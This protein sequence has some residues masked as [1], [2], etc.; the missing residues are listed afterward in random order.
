MA[1]KNKTELKAESS[2]TFPTNGVRQI[3]A[4]NHRAFN[5]DL[6]DSLDTVVYNG[7]I[8]QIK[9]VYVNRQLLVYGSWGLPNSAGLG[10]MDLIPMTSIKDQLLSNVLE[11]RMIYRTVSS[12]DL[13]PSTTFMDTNWLPLV[14][15]LMPSFPTNLS[16]RVQNSSNTLINSWVLLEI[17]YIPAE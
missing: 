6:I 14:P 8:K 9:K 10:A 2:S 7:S 13:S 4:A 17:T 11:V 1:Y 5:E 15:A 16:C 12:T 3:T